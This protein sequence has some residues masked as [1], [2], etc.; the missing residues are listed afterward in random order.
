MPLLQGDEGGAADVM[1][2][3]ALIASFLSGGG[4]VYSVFSEARWVVSLRLHPCPVRPPDTQFWGD[5]LRFLSL[6]VRQAPL[7]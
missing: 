6:S 2:G 4:A 1:G 5:S 3:Q 7:T